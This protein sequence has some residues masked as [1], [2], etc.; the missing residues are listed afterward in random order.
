MNNSTE[1]NPVREKS[2]PFQTRRIS[3]VDDDESV[4]E[5]IKGLF[6]SVGLRADVYAS[7]REFLESDAPTDT[8]CLILDVRMPGMSGLELQARLAASH[9]K[10]PIIFITAH[11]SDRQAR[12]RALKAGAVDFLLKPFKDEV[13]LQHVYEALETG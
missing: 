5:A 7:G 1:S 9:Y 10:I 2:K 6:R 12:T 13:L 3:I 11:A 4:R 8:A